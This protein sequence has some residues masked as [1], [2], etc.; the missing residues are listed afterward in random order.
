MA[1]KPWLQLAGVTL[2]AVIV[3]VVVTTGLRRKDAATPGASIL[4]VSAEGAAENGAVAAATGQAE[5]VPQIASMTQAAPSNQR[6]EVTPESW[7][8]VAARVLASEPPNGDSGHDTLLK[9]LQRALYPDPAADQKLGFSVSDPFAVEAPMA[10]DIAKMATYNPLGR[11]LSEAEL[12]D[13]Q[14]MINSNTATLRSCKRDVYLATQIDLIDAIRREDYETVPYG[15][16][17]DGLVQKVAKEMGA[18]FVNSKDANLTYLPGRDMTHSR[19][20]AL[21][22]EASPGYF[23]ALDRQRT[24]QSEFEIGLRSFF[25]DGSRR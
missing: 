16:D 1:T 3:V 7:E 22:R 9:H 17:P 21:R 13:L 11:A 25:L 19:V 18:K 6:T 2:L 5:P 8:Q 15:S 12:A 23:R 4:P 10:A 24:L 20:V 14:A